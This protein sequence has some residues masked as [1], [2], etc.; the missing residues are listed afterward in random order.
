[1][2]SVL[3]VG[4]RLGAGIR[5][6]EKALDPEGE[7][8]GVAALGHVTRGHP[9]A[10]G[11]QVVRPQPASGV[12][13]DVSAPGAQPMAGLVV[14]GNPD[15]G[16]AVDGPSAD[17]RARHPVVLA[18]VR[19]RLA[20][21]REVQHV[22]ELLEHFLRVREVL[23]ESLELVGL[24]TAAEAQHEASIGQAVHHPDL[25]EHPRRVIERGDDD[26]GG[27]LDAGGFA[28][29][30]RRHDEGR[31]ADAVV[32]EVV[33]GEPGDLEAEPVRLPHLL[34][35]LLEHALRR[36]PALPV[37]HQSEIAEVHRLLP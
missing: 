10:H 12:H 13:R 8:V 29:A 17:V 21:E 7:G 27:E 6:A 14:A 35:V 1:M 28:G 15:L 18:F 23:P 34:E 3:D 22:E 16:D 25:G 4:E 36:G 5:D 31:G 32:R 24:V 33:L 26:G 20:R 37:P 19:E 2:A 9:L 11:L 30:A